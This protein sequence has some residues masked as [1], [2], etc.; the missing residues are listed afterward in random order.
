MSLLVRTAGTCLALCKIRI[1]LFSCLSAATGFLLSARWV[2]PEMVVL[3]I[4]I[5]FL[6]CGSSALNQWQERDSDL[7]MSRTR[8]RPI[9]SGMIRPSHARCFSL[10]LIFLG[11]IA[12]LLTGKIAAPLLGLSA[13]FW[14]NGVYTPLKKRTAFAAVPGALVGAV[15]PA[16]GWITGG[17]DLQE[18]ELLALCFFFFLWQIPHF[19][20]LV[21]SHGEEYREAGFPAL[22]GIFTRPQLS[23]MI[24]NWIVATAVSSL[25]LSVYSAPGSSL[26]N[27][28]LTVLSLWLVWNGI[29]LLRGQ[30]GERLCALT[31]RRMN[32]YMFIVML[33]LSLDKLLIHLP[34]FKA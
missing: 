3:M 32:A 8:N 24:F 15:P 25:I 28:L 13:V 29:Q 30:G 18:P 17:G 2:K 20:L 6:A 26:V 27:V 9:P 31:F 16:V 11:S 33:L 22:T 19:W 23:R 7:I 10:I 34:V 12:L 4:G 1:S 5:C 14:Y 21:L